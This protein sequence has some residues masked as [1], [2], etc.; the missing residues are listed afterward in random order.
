MEQAHES[1][2]AQE[3]EKRRTRLLA[4]MKVK[5]GIEI[6][7]DQYEVCGGAHCDLDRWD[8]Q[9]L[10]W[11]QGISPPIPLV[12]PSFLFP[13]PSPFGNRQTAGSERLRLWTSSSIIWL[14]PKCSLAAW[15][16]TLV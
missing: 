9:H 6:M 3:L 13:P 15:K 8:A 5:Q 1:E 2:L 10:G 14:R 16:K 12:M 4:E 7:L 11:S